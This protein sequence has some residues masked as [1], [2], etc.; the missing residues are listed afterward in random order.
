MTGGTI[1]A[2]NGGIIYVSNAVA[3]I[4]L[5]NVA[6]NT[7]E[8]NDFFLQCTG[9]NN[10]EPPTI[11]G[12]VGSN[13]GTC[14]ITIINQE[15]DGDVIWDSISRVDF[16]ITEGS[17]F[18]GAVIDDETAV[19]DSEDIQATGSC[20]IT[21]DETST[22]VV[23]GNST[24]SDLENA[25]KIVDANGNTVTIQSVNGKVY[26]EGTSGYVVTVDFYSE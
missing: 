22:W 2:N 9:N 13:G 12:T 6:I 3:T 17:T 8:S 19:G 1:T 5:E 14:D 4:T 10:P 11:M 26:V 18:K 7:S 15:I 23:T 25:G 21:I 20:S 24:V 16:E